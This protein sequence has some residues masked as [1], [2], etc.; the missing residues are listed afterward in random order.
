MLLSI[1]YPRRFVVCWF[2]LFYFFS[3]SSTNCSISYREFFFILSR[4]DVCMHEDKVNFSFLF[5]LMF[6]SYVLSKNMYYFHY[7]Q[8]MCNITFWFWWLFICKKF[9]FFIYF[10][11]ENTT[12]KCYSR[13]EV[14]QKILYFYD[15]KKNWKRYKWVYQWQTYNKLH[16][17]ASNISSANISYHHY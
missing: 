5:C 12:N 16:N 9:F 6:S 7:K 2:S 10:N 17:I 14:I 1:S 13:I 8:H 15:E 4:Y 3:I 11:K